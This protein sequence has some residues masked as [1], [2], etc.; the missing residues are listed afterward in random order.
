MVGFSAPT[1]QKPEE[2]ALFFRPIAQKRR[3]WRIKR[4]STPKNWGEIA[5][6][7]EKS[8][9]TPQITHKVQKTPPRPSKTPLSAE[10]GPT[11]RT[12]RAFLQKRPK[13]RHFCQ[14]AGQTRRGPRFRRQGAQKMA[15]KPCNLWVFLTTTP[16]NPGKIAIF[17]EK[18]T[19]T[20]QITYKMQKR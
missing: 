11:A 3:K 17:F 13:T 2:K 8:A 12:F 7:S 4:N 6:F 20:P 5:N 19:K 1:P 16:K 14:F 18:R 9:K 10:K 15:P